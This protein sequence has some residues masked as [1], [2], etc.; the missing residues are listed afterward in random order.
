MTR[1]LL[2]ALR[3]ALP[4]CAAAPL[5]LLRGADASAPAPQPAASALPVDTT[6]TAGSAEMVSTDTETTF[7]LRDRVTV[8]GTNLRIICDELI[9]V[10][11]R[12]GDTKATLGNPQSFKSLVATGK[13]IIVQGDRE[14]TCERAEIFPADDRVVL[15]GTPHPRVRTLDGQYDAT[16]P[17]MELLRGQ[18]IARLL[19]E[20]GTPVRFTL[21]PLKDLGFDPNAPKEPPRDGTPTVPAPATPAVTVPIPPAKK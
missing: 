6:I 20:D 15:S 18:R 10:M 19:S 3:L 4:L 14:A 9:V 2:A 16:S 5:A 1:R 7:I 12:R 13:V 11:R 21:P 8:A 17:R